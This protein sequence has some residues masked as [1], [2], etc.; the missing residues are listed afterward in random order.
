MT[1]ADR[2]RSIGFAEGVQRGF[3]LDDAVPFRQFMLEIYDYRCAV[4][5]QA[6]ASDE[7]DQHLEV[8]LFQPLGH[9]GQMAPG[10][11]VVVD[12]VVAG[13]LGKGHLLISDAYRAYTSHPE[14]VSEPVEPSDAHGRN[15]VLPDNVSLWPQR[16]MVGYHRSLFRAQ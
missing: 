10:N 4:T 13:L 11:A 12:P 7:A 14:I 15:M 1:V 6:Y 9:G 3:A 5:G 2:D 8:F 16:D